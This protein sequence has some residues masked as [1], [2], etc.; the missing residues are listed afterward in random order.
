MLTDNLHAAATGCDFSELRRREFARLDANG[1]AYLDYT[2]A[3]LYPDSLVRSHAAMLRDAVL[4]NPHSDS[5]A[6][7]GSSASIAEARARVLR[8]FDASPDEYEVCFTANASSAVRLVA[9]S[10]PFTPVTPLVLSADNHNSVNGIREYA[11]AR[12]A[13]VHYLPLDS[14]L[15]LAQPDAGLRAFRPVLGA[16]GLLAYPAQSN[17][18]GVRHSLALVR[19]AQALGYHVLLDAAA[20]APTSALSLLEVPADYLVVSMYKMFGYPTGIGALIAR[21]KALAMLG[22]PWFSG[23]T[24]E[25]VSVQGG[26]HMLREGAE[27]FEDGTA[28]FL[29]LSAVTAGLEFLE[30]LGMDRIAG[31]VGSLSVFLIDEL[32]KLRHP[33]GIPMI[34]LYGTSGH[35]SRGGTVSFNVIDERGQFVPFAL[36]EARA[37][38]ALVSVRGGCF[39]NPGASEAAFGFPGGRAVRCLEQ[40]RRDG[41]SIPRFAECM[42]GHAVGAVRASLGIA[43]NERDIARLVD[44]LAGMRA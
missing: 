37:C 5:P 10:Y 6:S 1:H 29:G 36:V 42:Q 24:V 9:E 38:E 43:S 16:R 40:G 13:P 20:F 14:D 17:F 39:C 34:R 3:A 19:T 32:R 27:G 8:H 41:F 26:M 25:F 22:R 4:G 12:G 30:R 33:N 31:H 44:V 28:N 7:L 21:R 23:G 11:R 35:H 15:R 2:G 18:S